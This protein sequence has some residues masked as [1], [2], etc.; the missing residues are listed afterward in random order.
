MWGAVMR[1]GTLGKACAV[2][3]D[4][5]WGGVCLWKNP[6][7]IAICRVKAFYDQSLEVWRPK[8]YQVQPMLAIHTRD[9]HQEL[10]I[11][12]GGGQ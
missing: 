6:E 8:A 4:R 7:E 2:N 3:V 12:A 11:W 10:M 1:V 9:L 5:G